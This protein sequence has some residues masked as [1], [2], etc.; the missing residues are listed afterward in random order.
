[1]RYQLY[2]NNRQGLC[3]S[4]TG[5]SIH[6]SCYGS[7]SSTGDVAKKQDKVDMILKAKINAALETHNGDAQT[8]REIQD[9]LNMYCVNVT[10]ARECNDK[11]TIRKLRRELVTYLNTKL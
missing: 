2:A 5:N 10:I 9:R 4:G 7:P 11:T 3:G 1:M 8:L 6:G